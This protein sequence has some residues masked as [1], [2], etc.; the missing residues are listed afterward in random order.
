[1]TT[2]VERWITYLI[3][4]IILSPI[5]YL[6]YQEVIGNQVNKNLILIVLIISST[7]FLYHLHSLIYYYTTKSYLIPYTIDACKT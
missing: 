1:M 4:L 3:H 2:H 7:G 6:S 5:I